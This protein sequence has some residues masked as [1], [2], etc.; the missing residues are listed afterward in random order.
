MHPRKIDAR[1]YS[2]DRRGIALIS[3]LLLCS[4]LL[5]MVM[6][7]VTVSR[8]QSFGASQHA[9]KLA[10]LYVAES[11]LALAADQLSQTPGWTTGWTDEPT[12]GGRG[13]F[14]IRFNTT[15][16]NIQPDESVNNLGGAAAVDGPRGADTVPPHTAVIVVVARAGGAER[17]VEAVLA[18]GTV[19]TEMSPLLSSGLIDLRG[20]LQ[21]QGI[22]S[23]EDT[24]EVDAG[25][26]SNR[27][28]GPGA[29]IAWTPLLPGD[30]ADVSGSVSSVASGAGAI[31]FGSD[32]SLYDTGGFDPGADVR[33]LPN[34]DVPATV[35]ANSSAPS[36][37]IT[38]GLMTLPAGKHY[39]PAGLSLQGD[40]VLQEGAE[41]YVEG[42]VDIN[43]ALR[44]QG[45]IFVNGDT[46]LRGDATL[47][48]RSRVALVSQ[49][50]VLLEGFDGAEYLNSVPGAAPI[51]ADVD[52]LVRRIVHH[53]DNPTDLTTGTMTATKAFT[54]VI[55]NGQILD[56]LKHH[57]GNDNVPPEDQWSYT[58]GIGWD[59]LGNLA[60]LLGTQ[61]QSETRD[62]LIKKISAYKDFCDNDNARTLLAKQANVQAF[63]DGGEVIPYAIEEVTDLAGAGTLPPGYDLDAALGIIRNQMD[64]LS[65]DKLGDSYFQGLV[66]SHGNV[67]TTNQI[68]VVG[69]LAAEGDLELLNGTH[70]TYVEDF[71][72]GDNPI[73]VAGALMV[74]SWVE[75]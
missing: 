74:R 1:I 70:I 31:D 61:P 8:Q 47:T 10:A 28:G 27:A 26:H 38:P 75:R 48:A 11:G 15:G 39:L 68:T 25:I 52:A 58:S 67:R 65:Y 4:I 17:R 9:N 42:D 50:D 43:G 46:H 73:T 29:T 19:L 59:R 63:L 66:Y 35:G 34:Y 72:S 62:F 69:A 14:T 44:G 60:T 24:E 21:I 32:P 33:A 57:L 37:P 16:V 20:G 6:A 36:P 54:A 5:V 3:T 51:M 30:R 18:R 49:G 12:V 64:S 71:F 45:T 7:M 23:L 2:V 13:T 53:L 56:N 41:L 40:L 55:G 22:R